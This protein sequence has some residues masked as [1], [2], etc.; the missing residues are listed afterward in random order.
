MSPLGVDYVRAR[1]YWANK[2]RAQLFLAAPVAP[3]AVLLHALFEQLD[4]DLLARLTGLFLTAIV[5]VAVWSVERQ[6][7]PRLSR[8]AIT[9][10]LFAIL[11]LELLFDHYGLALF[12]LVT[13]LVFFS[14]TIVFA[15]RQVLFSGS[16]DFNKIVGAI[17]IYIFLA[18]VW[19]LTYLLVEHFFPGSIPGLESEDWRESM[20]L[21]IYYSFVTMTTLGFGD[22]SP[23]QPLARYLTYLEAV[24]GQFYIAILVAS[25]IGV[26]LADYHKSAR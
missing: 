15:C 17:C 21:A 7:Y 13:L 4:S 6:H 8:I 5:L 10:L 9:V 19:A 16:V 26:R 20:Q 24:A 2:T 25:L 1:H 11:A 18:L 22:I 3:G 14:L 23:L 12:Q